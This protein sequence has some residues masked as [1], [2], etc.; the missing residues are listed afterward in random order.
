METEYSENIKVCKECKGI[1]KFE[2]YDRPVGKS[3]KEHLSQW[4]QKV[5]CC[6]GCKNLYWKRKSKEYQDK[7]GNTFYKLR[8]KLFERDNFRCVYC[9]RSPIEDG[10]VLEVEHINPRN[11]TSPEWNNTQ[12]KELVTACKDCN[13][14]KRD[15]K[16]SLPIIKR[17]ENK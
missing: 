9:G 3:K 11:G 14:G 5:Y 2:D 7:R 1:F 4:K 17:L 15:R 16:L 10:V 8:F 12:L 13:I 6:D